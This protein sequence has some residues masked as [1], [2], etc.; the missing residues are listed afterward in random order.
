MT[1]L[2]RLP[3]LCAGFNLA[4]AEDLAQLPNTVVLA[5]SENEAQA[6]IAGD[7]AVAIDLGDLSL[8]D[9]TCGGTS[10]A[11]LCVHSLATL[12]R[13]KGAENPA[14]AQAD[15]R[16]RVSDALQVRPDT[17]AWLVHA[18]VQAAALGPAT[19]ASVIF[20]TGRRLAGN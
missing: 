18:S 14:T 13:M 5:S 15:R 17:P 1:W 12:I 7:Q 6:I 2:D 10:V 8:C 3:E 11:G 16:A 9:C 4:D 20:E 19:K